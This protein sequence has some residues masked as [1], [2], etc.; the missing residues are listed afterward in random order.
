[1]ILNEINVGEKMKK[2]FQ[3]TGMTCSACAARIERV[4]NKNEY[5]TNAS[6]NFAA[7]TLAVD[8]DEKSMTEKQVIEIIN[9]AGYGVQDKNSKPPM[10]HQKVMLIRFIISVIFALP[11]LVISMGH[12]L[13]SMPLP[14]IIDPHF[15]PLNFSLL[16][17]LLTVP[18][19]ITGFR[20]Y[21]TGY[22]N[23]F[24]LYP[25]MDSLIAVS[26][27]A[28]F[29]YSL[30]S[31][32]MITKGN[33]EYSMNLYFESVAV[34]LTLITLGKYLEAVCKGKSSEAIK[35]LM[36]LSPKTAHII[37]NNKEVE[38]KIENV[39]IGDIV[40]VKPGEKFPVDGVVTEG[41]TSADESMLTGESIPVDKQPGSSII[42]A[43][44]NKSGY[45]RYQATKVGADTALS[46][47]IKLVEDAQGSK[48][49]IARLADKISAVFVPT[50][51]GLAVL[52]AVIW[53][54]AGESP[55][56]VLKIFVSVLTIACPCAL[57][58]A[59][60]TAIMVGTGKGAQKGI[61][62][63]S[64][65]ALENL[66]KINTIV[67]DKT[68]T[69]T[70]GK[71]KVT[72]IITY[73]TYPQNDLLRIAASA[74]KGSEHAL[75]EAIVNLA[76]EKNIELSSLDEFTS[77]TG[78]GLQATVEHRR[79]LI[80]NKK[81]M[82]DNGVILN[83]FDKQGDTL[84]SEGKTP[85]YIAADGKMAGIIAVADTVKKESRE[86]V[87][88]LRKLGIEVYMVTGDNKKTADSMAKQTGIENVISD[89]LPG[90]KARIIRELQAKGKITAMAGDGINDA[91]A[92]AEADIGIAVG[93]GTDVAIESADIVLM[94]S[95]LNDVTD[96]IRLSRATIKNIKENLFWAFGYNVIGIPVA[97]GLLYL[98]GG[99][100]LNP[101]IA[102][103]AMSFSSVS[104]LL[105]AMR[106]K[107]FR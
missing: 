78:H 55:T 39:K 63:N 8:Y 49:P 28:A 51:I 11:L 7:E 4:L 27:T 73:G 89:V 2:N 62:I 65:E 60:P 102:A 38:I 25:N 76:K 103:L 5:V 66:Y 15:N 22:R 86:A 98:F 64:S 69:L 16:Q 90:D 43:S 12:M 80:G 9:K 87:A 93:T 72:N 47:I 56:F 71:P 97:M 68:G 24:K 83:D 101:M 30:Y 31:I 26:T 100:L 3:I 107:R 48:A 29:L 58:L 84:S 46:Q 32:Y 67:F 61:L 6:V 1:M 85:V 92:L 74:E 42:G 40:V 70:E 17:I 19:M 14:Q 36:G 96:A 77:L 82:S 106:L 81:L 79:V 57:G 53:S 23:L 18:V 104:V 59:T 34:I 91:P 35:K 33:N 99:P 105:N 13:F 50:V 41:T 10:S 21:T 20:Y 52:A 45:I 37:K 44:I 75:G 54:I 94:H 95:N 88:K